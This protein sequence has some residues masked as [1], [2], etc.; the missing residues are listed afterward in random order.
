VHLKL[1]RE[2][3]ALLGS[4]ALKS[5]MAQLIEALMHKGLKIGVKRS[6]G[7]TFERLRES[8]AKVESLTGEIQSMLAASFRQLNA[9][10]GF[11]LQV[12]AQPQ[13]AQYVIDIN[14]V[15]R[16]HLQYLGIGNMFKLTQ[17]EFTDR[18]VRALASRLRGVRESA[19]VEIE[20]WSKSAAAQ[21][22][23]QLRERRRSFARRIEAI[24]R[25]QQAA[26]GLEERMAALDRQEASLNQLDAKL[27]E[28]TAPLVAAQATAEQ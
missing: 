19:L 6:Y 21:L 9:E 4:T 7:A 8:L 25:I 15:E 14:A 1:L 13:V 22:D 11:S 20:L 26:G 23:A 10:Y 12:P 5:E 28:L 18:L 16:S 27:L 2:V 3:F 17:P 24:D